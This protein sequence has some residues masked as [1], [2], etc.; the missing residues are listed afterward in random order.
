RHVGSTV[1][2]ALAAA[3]PSLDA[4][5]AAS[6]EDL[7]AI[8]GVGPRIAASV[9]AFFANPDNTAVLERLRDAG[10]RTEDEAREVRPQTLAGTTW[11]LTGALEHLTRDEATAALKA[12]GAKVTGSVSAKTSYVVVGADPGSKYTRALELGV[13]VLDEGQLQATLEDGVVPE[14]EG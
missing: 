10:V 12:L 6:E 7:A 3:Y 5:A 1:A 8:E 9:R 11:V 4:L 2:E 14:G 13:P